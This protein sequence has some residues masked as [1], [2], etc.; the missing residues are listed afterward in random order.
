MT[1]SSIGDMAQLLV[2]RQNTMMLK[3]NLNTLTNELSSGRVSDVAAHLGTSQNRL[4]MIDSALTRL[5][6]FDLAASEME[7]ALHV[8]QISLSDIQTQSSDVAQQFMLMDSAAND[9]QLKLGSDQ[10]QQTLDTVISRLNATVAGRPVFGGTAVHGPVVV[11]AE[12]LLAQVRAHLATTGATSA[13][14]IVSEVTDWFN[15]PT[16]F[17][18]TAYGGEVTNRSQFVADGQLAE[19]NVRADGDE[20]K[21]LLSGLVLGALADDTG[22]SATDARA[23]IGASAD[24]LL[25]ANGSLASR[26][27]I[28]G[29]S[30]ERVEDAQVANSALR[31]AWNMQRNDLVSIDQF[32]TASKLQDAQTQLELHYAVTARLSSLS[33]AGYL[34]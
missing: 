23:L 2:S 5:N 33:L 32:E 6:A 24:T 21:Q 27:G 10:A 1:M 4:S 34:R 31:T 19:V 20:I 13:S 22:I 9:A 3:S 16:D 15:D 18:A 25:S 11:A 7:Q 28:V 8:V 26:Q 12:D 17:A 14:D 29:N 30:Q